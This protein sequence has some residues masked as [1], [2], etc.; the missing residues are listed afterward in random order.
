MALSYLEKELIYL[1]KAY[2][3]IKDEVIG[4]ML[5]LRDPSHQ[6]AMRKWMETHTSATVDE[7][8]EEALFI[9]DNK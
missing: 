5:I 3:A 7:I 1:L 6:K 8:I 9:R 2:E 4:I